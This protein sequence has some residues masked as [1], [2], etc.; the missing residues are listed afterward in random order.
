M[1]VHP[2]LQCTPIEDYVECLP[3]GTKGWTNEIDCF[4]EMQDMRGESLSL[5]DAHACGSG[6]QT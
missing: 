4:Y 1:Q 2:D 6:C 5:L 3:N